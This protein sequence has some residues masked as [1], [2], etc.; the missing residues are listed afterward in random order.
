VLIVLRVYA[1][2]IIVIGNYDKKKEYLKQRL[3]LEF[4]LKELGR[5]KYF[6]G[7]EILL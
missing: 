5:L 7:I 3:V 6:L 2:D 4:E 1:D